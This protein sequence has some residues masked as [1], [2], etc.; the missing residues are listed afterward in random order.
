MIRD[1]EFAGKDYFSILKEI[2]GIIAKARYNAFTA[3]NTE[4]LKA[5][6]EIGKKIVE[7][8]Q[9]GEKRAGYGERLLMSKDKGALIE[10]EKKGNVPSKTEELIKD[11]YVL[12]FLDLDEK[13]TY[14]EKDKVQVEYAVSGMSNKMFVSKYKLYLP[15]KEELEREV[16]KLL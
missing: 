6:F 5:Y 12:E 11:P 8:E 1:K 13:K 16:R 2:K 9:R 14:T 4:M 15:T 3:L 10:Y 7:E